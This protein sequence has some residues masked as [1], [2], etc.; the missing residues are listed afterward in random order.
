MITI[1]AQYAYIYLVGALTVVWIILYTLNPRTHKQQLFMSLIFSPLATIAEILYFKDYW[2]PLS[3][4]SGNIRPVRI[5]LE[6]FI[7]AFC[8][9]GIASVI[10]KPFLRDSRKYLNQ[11]NTNF[12][13]L[14]LLTVLL[15]WGLFILGINSIYAASLSFL[16]SA[17]LMIFWRKNLLRD[18][19]LSGLGTC[20]VMFFIYALGFYITKNSEDILRQIWYLYGTTLGTRVLGVPLT[21]L[22][23][24][25]TL[26]M[27]I[28]PLYTFFKTE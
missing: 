19:F 1:T 2:N 14:I 9:V 13:I 17:S 16:S 4:L 11:N 25:F 21:E 8:I 15:S 7:F 27:F 23:W 24:A 12:L 26:G 5:L 22:I 20:L 3:I 18:S 6:D 10:A 28:G